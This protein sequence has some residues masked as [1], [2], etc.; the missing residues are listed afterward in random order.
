VSQIG[1][2][3]LAPEIFVCPNPGTR[4]RE[5]RPRV[6]LEVPMHR[7]AEHSRGTRVELRGG[8]HARCPMFDPLHD[9]RRLDLLHASERDAKRAIA[10]STD[11][12]EETQ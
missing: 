2:S 12:I 6:M 4:W 8:Q 9:R 3:L 10:G 11:V 7:G 5:E 1:R